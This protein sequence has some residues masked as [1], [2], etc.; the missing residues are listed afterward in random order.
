MFY[1]SAG[2]FS[3]PTLASVP[4]GKK[5]NHFIFNAKL[6]FLKPKAQKVSVE[7]CLLKHEYKKFHFLKSFVVH[8]SNK[9]D[10]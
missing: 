7:L 5:K 3:M 9:W 6:Y 2:T 1:L 4:I 10:V 8:Q